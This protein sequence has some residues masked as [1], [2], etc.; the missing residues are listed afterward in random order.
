MHVEQMEYLLTEKYAYETPQVGEI[1]TGILLEIDDHGA[2]VDIGLK[3]DGIVPR[4]DIER[5]DDKTLSK[6]VPGQEVTT[7]IIKAQD[8]EDNL[9]LS[10]SYIQEK[11]D[12]EKA[13]AMFTNDQ[14]DSGKVIGYNQGGLLIKF[15]TITGFIPVSHLWERSA[16]RALKVKRKG[17]LSR[18]MS[19]ELSFKIIEVNEETNR[20]VMSERLAEQDLR[21]QSREKLIRE[22][23][24]GQTR[25]GIVT[26]LSDFGAFVDLG[27]ID[28]LIHISEL[29]W[30]RIQHP[31]EIVQVGDEVDVYILDVDH[32][33]K[34]ISLSLKQLQKNPWERV[35][36]VYYIGQLVHGTVTNVVNFGAFI[37][38]DIG[39]EGLLHISE[40]ADPTPHDPREFIQRGDQLVVRILRVE[41]ER[42][43]IELSLKDVSESE[44]EM[45]LAMQAQK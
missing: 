10:L 40:I 25:S 45:Y 29:A 22:F 34:R 18:Y 39:I 44:R 31:S 35:E 3:H 26:H 19:Q 32:E 9:L 11:K 43:R 14:I 21:E 5:L 24:E 12:W 36:D 1:R 13:Q 41:G 15:G 30:R 6:L 8:R 20:L 28:G 7:R 16:H 42:Q 37:A 4:T 17:V 2:V 38:L 27:D 33:R 23:E